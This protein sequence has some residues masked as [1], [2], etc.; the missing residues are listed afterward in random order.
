MYFHFGIDFS[1]ILLHIGRYFLLFSS[2]H[3]QTYY[4]FISIL[5]T[6]LHH[7]LNSMIFIL[8]SIVN[9]FNRSHLNYLTLLL[10]MCLGM[11]RRLI[12]NMLTLNE[13]FFLTLLSSMLI[14]LASCIHR[15]IF[16]SK[17]SIMM[18]LMLMLKSILICFLKIILSNF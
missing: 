4:S 16:I 15:K 12:R 5:K 17:T 6:V 1:S 2:Y 18:H 3:Q 7:L 8:L 11:C 13:L 14:L 9:I 10:N